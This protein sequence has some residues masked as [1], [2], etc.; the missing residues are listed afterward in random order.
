MLLAWP[1]AW[2]LWGLCSLLQRPGT[3]DTLSPRL[4]FGLALSHPASFS[5]SVAL[6]LKSCFLREAWLVILL[7]QCQEQLTEYSLAQGRGC[8]LSVQGETGCLP[9]CEQPSSEDPQT[10]LH[11]AW[12]NRLQGK[13]DLSNSSSLRKGPS[14]LNRV[15][16]KKFIT[17]SIYSVLYRTFIII[18]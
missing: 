1:N 3:P 14:N 17:I 18:D 7:Q 6:S 13:D 2:A 5:F 16:W 4:L 9:A 15:G 10:H 12:E 11:S 8:S